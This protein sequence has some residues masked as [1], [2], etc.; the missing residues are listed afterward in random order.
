MEELPSPKRSRQTPDICGLCGTTLQATAPRHQ[1]SCVRCSINASAIYPDSTFD[2]VQPEED[3]NN[4]ENV[5][6]D[7]LRDGLPEHETEI[8]RRP[9]EVTIHIPSCASRHATLPDLRYDCPV[10]SGLSFCSRCRKSHS[11][12]AL[13]A[14]TGPIDDDASLDDPDSDGDDVGN[15]QNGSGFAVDEVGVAIGVDGVRES[16]LDQLV[17]HGDRSS[18]VGSG[19]V[20]DN[21][22]A[23][24]SQDLDRLNSEKSDQGS[25]YDSDEEASDQEG[26]SNASMPLQLSKP[27]QDFL[28]V[29]Y[30]DFAQMT[31]RMT[32]V[33]DSM[34][35]MVRAAEE[36]LTRSTSA[37]RTLKPAY[38]RTQSGSKEIPETVLV[39]KSLLNF[40]IDLATLN[41]NEGRR[42]GNESTNHGRRTSSRQWT[43]Q[44]RHQLSK[45][46]EKGWTDEI[47]GA[48]LNRTASAV[49]Q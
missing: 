8:D 21:D 30:E 43:A 23:E 37:R 45:L 42:T 33:M 44:D 1:C 5:A 20:S 3:G 28:Q 38:R 19:V 34:Q 18:G 4:T 12:H 39:P 26:I 15:D 10:C 13:K 46:K 32:Q 36:I 29:S 6:G 14:M 9:P 25:G 7:A 49:S 47:I 40:P 41:P 11:H 31:R 16:S 17:D 48:V 24:G 22:D 27:S 35:S 2:L